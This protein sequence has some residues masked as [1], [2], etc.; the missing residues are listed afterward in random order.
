MSFSI[1]VE[2]LSSDRE[3]VY[4]FGDTANAFGA[5]S[6]RRKDLLDAMSYRTP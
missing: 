2:M 5:G 6:E 3:A 4:G 1:S